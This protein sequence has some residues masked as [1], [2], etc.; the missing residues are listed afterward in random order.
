M[1]ISAYGPSPG[2]KGR[3]ALDIRQLRYFLTVAREGQITR[4]AARLHMAQ[5]PLSQQ[6]RLLEEELH[7]RLFNRTGHGVV[8]TSAGVVLR[9]RAEQVLEMMDSTRKELTDLH[10]GI[11]GMLNIGTVASCGAGL[12][13]RLMR[14]FHAAYPHV[15]FQIWEGDTFR[16]AELLA[17]G[18]VEIGIVRTPFRNDDLNAAAADGSPRSDPMAAAGRPDMLGGTGPMA[19]GQLRGR[20]L[21]LHR[22]YETLFADACRGAGF[23]P[24][25]VCRGD[26]IRS[27]LICAESGL[28]I[29]IVPES[30]VGPSGCRGLTV[31]RIDAPSLCTGV[32]VVWP[33]NRYLS[34][35]AQRMIGLFSESSA[36]PK[37]ARPI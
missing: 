37:Q 12:L 18:V 34:V 19:L 28:G 21:I 23:D 2:R 22:R 36:P 29:A 33:K 10:E 4:A 17:R 15:V 30:T 3:P 25:V 16:V 35:A 5:P 27:L 13:P 20:P 1:D 9:E 31:R 32:A 7:V 8:L 6:I 24:R 11:H 14:R 26:D